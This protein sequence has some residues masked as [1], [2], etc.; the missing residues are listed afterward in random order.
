MEILNTILPIVYIVVGVALVW[1]VIE[2][3]LTIRKTRTV[4]SDVK[5]QIDPT[6]ENVA[7]LTDDAKP[8]VERVSL[9][10][11]AA[12]L[13]I[14]RVDEILQ[15]VSNITDTA[16][17]AV[18]TVD[19]ITNAPLE[20]VNS[21]TNK[22]RN[23]FEPKSASKESEQMGKSKSDVVEKVEDAMVSEIDEDTSPAAE[24]KDIPVNKGYT[25]VIADV[26]DAHGK[27]EE[28]EVPSDGLKQDGSESKSNS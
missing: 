7:Q 4:V 14:M 17:K 19:N 15:D 18:T 26:E 28:F 24:E 25:P 11:D 22:V 8:L 16:S 10:V 13:E 5:D 6:L 1:F 9:T 23:K 21:L 3:A 20:L 2:L 12:N 27:E